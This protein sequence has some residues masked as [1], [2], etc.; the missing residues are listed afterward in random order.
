MRFVINDFLG[1][2]QKF[3]EQ[4]FQRTQLAW[5]L[6]VILFN[7]SLKITRAPVNPLMSGGNE[8]LIHT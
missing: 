1:I 5:H 6:C 7:Y 3:S 2:S 8:R 4:L